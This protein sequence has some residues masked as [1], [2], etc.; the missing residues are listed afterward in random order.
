MAKSGGIFKEYAIYFGEIRQRLVSVLIALGIG[1]G[2][3]FLF[4]NKILIFCLH[5]FNFSGVNVMVT[6]PVQL[7]NLQIYTGLLC[8][9]LAALPFFIYQTITFARPAFK[10][11][12]YRVIKKMLP[13]S[14][15]LFII[16][17]IF[18]AW[19]TQ[20][21]I[22][23]YSKYSTEFQVN[24]MWDIQKFFSQ[25][26]MTAVLMGL[27]FQMPIILTVLM[28]LGI[29]KR[30]FLASKRRYVYVILLIIGV[31]LPPTDILSLIL[32][33]TPLLFLFEI[34]L[35]LNMNNE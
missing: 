8:G 18:G 1:G 2:L 16:G 17:A 31:L 3:G 29:V 20:F 21:I 5:M 22:A 26:I 15:T 6:S 24:N 23:I 33:V 10:E 7:I 11:K 30:K 19:V 4:S 28:R 12:E 14:V 34:A 35:L 32:L 27:I 9:F 13:L 25:V